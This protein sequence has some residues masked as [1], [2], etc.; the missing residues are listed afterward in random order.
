MFESCQPMTWKTKHEQNDSAHKIHIFSSYFL[1]SSSIIKDEYKQYKQYILVYI[2]EISNWKYWFCKSN[3]FSCRANMFQYG[4]N[5]FIIQYSSDYKNYKLKNVN[6]SI[7]IK[8]IT[9]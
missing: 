1:S 6:L 8:Y 5:I 9:K 4:S 2:V 7:D 3:I